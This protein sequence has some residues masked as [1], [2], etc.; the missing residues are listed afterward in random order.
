MKNF[1]RRQFIRTGSGVALGMVAVPNILNSCVAPSRQITIGMIGT[2]GHCMDWNL[3]PYL[4]MEDVHVVAVCDVDRERMLNAK[5]IVDEKYQNSDCATYGDFRDLLARPDIDVVHISTPDHWHV[6]ISIL[7][8]QAGKD[9]ICEK[10]TLAIAEGRVLCEVMKK[11][12]KIYQTSIEDRAIPVYH[13]M[14]ELVRNGYIG[15]LQKI[16]IRVPDNDVLQMNPASTETQ[17]V[18]EG[19][20][21]DMW[22]GPAPYAPYSPGR[23][24]WNFRW[25]SDYSGG[26][27]TDW[28]AHYVD[29]AQWAN[30]TD[31]SGPISAEGTAQ[32]LS[33]SIY[34][35]ANIFDLHY[36]YA[37]GVTMQVVSGGTSIGFQG[38]EGWIQCL[39][40]RGDL[41]AS[42][43]SLLSVQFKNSD[44]RLYT[45]ENEHR[46]FIDCVKSRKETFVP[47]E[48]G[49]RTSSALHVGNIAMKLGRKVSW[50]PDKEEFINDP[51]ANSLR[52]RIS[53]D[54]WKLENIVI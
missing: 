15:Q 24:H 7:A 34:D 46:N 18:P 54:P 44:I 10:P 3:P 17:P 8:A 23:C 43:S 49:H 35:T 39:G 19:F 36:E 37:N 13:R 9:V 25:I 5:K 1:N 31:H 45:A 6:P 41:E 29:T 12:K 32:F 51:D 16:I 38:T 26:M 42:K 53:R 27:L 14:A 50:N 11:H 22:L 47:V 52:S 4:G 40:W 48:V 28:G 20:D 2:G 33:G 21:Y 30:G